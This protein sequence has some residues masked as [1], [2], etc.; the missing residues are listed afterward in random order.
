MTT[1]MMRFVPVLGVLV[2]LAQ[3]A[4]AQQ[5]SDPEHTL[6]SAS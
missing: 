5:G 3:G 1:K 6:P 4:V 2:L